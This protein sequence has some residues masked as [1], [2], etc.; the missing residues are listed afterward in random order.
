[1]PLD[2]KIIRERYLATGDNY[3]LAALCDELDAARKEIDAL[4]LAVRRVLM[5]WGAG[6]AVCDALMD[7]DET[8]GT[9]DRLAATA[10]CS[11]EG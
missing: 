1:M 5:S 7:L 3:P 2:T 10:G 9:S 4:L 8:V 6:N 11:A